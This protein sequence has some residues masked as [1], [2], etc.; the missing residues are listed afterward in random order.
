MTPP[1]GDTG[2]PGTPVP[3]ASSTQAACSASMSACW[4]PDLVK[5]EDRFTLAMLLRY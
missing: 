5:Y 4:Q 3:L 2:T 1:G